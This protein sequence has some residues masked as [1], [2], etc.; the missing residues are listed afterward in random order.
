MTVTVNEKLEAALL[1]VLRAEC[2]P[3]LLPNLVPRL[4]KAAIGVLGEDRCTCQQAVHERCHKGL[5]DRC[6]WCV[7]LPEPRQPYTP[8]GMTEVE[9]KENLL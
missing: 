7:R 6:P 2:P 9:V 5:V 3:G 8:T 4:A 1:D